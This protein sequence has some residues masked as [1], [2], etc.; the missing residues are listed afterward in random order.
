[1]RKRIAEYAKDAQ[2]AGRLRK[3]LAEYALCEERAMRKQYVRYSRS[4]HSVRIPPY[5]MQSPPNM[6]EACGLNAL[7]EIQEYPHLYL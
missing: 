4:A 3:R 5:G 1:M 2:K 6:L 7:H